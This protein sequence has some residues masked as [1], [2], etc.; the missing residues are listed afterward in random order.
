MKKINH[1]GFT[2]VELLIVIVVIG[3]LAAITIVAY[4]G[5]Q[6][7]ARASSASSALSQAAKKIAVW[8]VD[9]PGTTPSTLATVG[10][11]NTTDVSFQYTPGTNGAY[12]ITATATNVSYTITESS[13]PTAGGCS[14]HGQGGVAAVTNLNTNPSF[15]TNLTSHAASRG[16]ISLDSTQYFSGVSSARFVTNGVAGTPYISSTIQTGN[17]NN[18]VVN[19]SMRAK[20]NT[21]AGS[22]QLRIYFRDASN[23]ILAPTAGVSGSIVALNSA[24]WVEATASGTAPVG[25]T[26]VV[27]YSLLI[28]GDF[29]SGIIFW[30]DSLMV[31]TGNSTN[32]A[33]G[34]SSNWVWNGT[35]H[36]STSTGPPQ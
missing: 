15:E 33:D 6:N 10:V 36:A 35:A 8:Q 20:R 22:L 24:S 23:T 11:S 9:N 3:I 16:V 27:I 26:N 7:R 30:Y 17:I 29:A 28:P 12:C 34:S 4:N 21:T 13:Q 31:N 1:R 14:G 19:T 32:Y 25:T 18:E 5:I 2:I